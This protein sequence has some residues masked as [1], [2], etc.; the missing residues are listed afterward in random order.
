M[1]I[2]QQGLMTKIELIMP[3]GDVAPILTALLNQPYN[4]DKLNG[5]ANALKLT[6]TEN[7]KAA[8]NGL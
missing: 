7:V 6:P 1:F 4:E 5:I 2:Y 8:I 3:T